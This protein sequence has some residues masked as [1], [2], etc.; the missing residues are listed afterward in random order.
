MAFLKDQ[1][2]DL[3]YFICTV[4]ELN[5]LGDKFDLTVH[6]YADEFTLYIGFNPLS[7]FQDVYERINC[8]LQKVQQWMTLKFL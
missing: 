2:W 4:Y 6:S 7:E 1:F 3:F 5:Y 8:C